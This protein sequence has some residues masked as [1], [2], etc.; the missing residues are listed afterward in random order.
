MPLQLFGHALQV[1][2]APGKLSSI[3]FAAFTAVGA[4]RKIRCVLT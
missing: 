1:L 4:S 3:F 2:V